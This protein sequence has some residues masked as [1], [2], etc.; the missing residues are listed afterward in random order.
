MINKPLAKT[1]GIKK[2]NKL[3]GIKITFYS[4]KPENKWLYLKTTKCDAVD[5]L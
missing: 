1:K 4:R 2:A 3:A 5:I